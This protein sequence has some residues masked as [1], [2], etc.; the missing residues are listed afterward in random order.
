MHIRGQDEQKPKNTM[1][2]EIAGIGIHCMYI[3]TISTIVIINTI[4]IITVRNLLLLHNDCGLNTGTLTNGCCG[5]VDVVWV[6]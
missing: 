6:L 3:M 2:T 4:I 5:D 1:Q